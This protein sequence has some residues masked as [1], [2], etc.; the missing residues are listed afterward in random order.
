M[1][2]DADLGERLKVI[3]LHGQQRNA[4]AGIV[5]DVQQALPAALDRFDGRVEQWPGLVKPFGAAAGLERS[6]RRRRNLASFRSG[7]KA[8]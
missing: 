7:I 1:A 4:L 2:T 5:P 8:A 6:Q 3:G